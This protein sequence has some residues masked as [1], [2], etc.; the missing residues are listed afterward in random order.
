MHNFG[1]LSFKPR[2]EYLPF[3]LVK[4]TSHAKR[5]YY[6][7]NFFPVGRIHR[8]L[9]CL[10]NSWFGNGD[11]VTFYFFK[12]AI[13]N[14]KIYQTLQRNTIAISS[15]VYSACFSRNRGA[16]IPI[17]TR[18]LTHCIG[19]GG[20]FV[21]G[22]PALRMVNAKNFKMAGKIMFNSI[23]FLFAKQAVIGRVK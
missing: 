10:A 2:A 23:P 17:K 13:G 6:F 16:L 3:K 1:T 21:G 22:H 8:Q 14:S 5:F 7:I 12:C 20:E 18:W 19:Y 4:N 9:I 15:L 11:A